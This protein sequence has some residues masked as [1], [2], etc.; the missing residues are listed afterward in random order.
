MSKRFNDILNSDSDN[1]LS[2][3]KTDIRNKQE[4]SDIIKDGQIDT[5]IHLGSNRQRNLI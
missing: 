1:K 3:H 2:F 4:I 5:C